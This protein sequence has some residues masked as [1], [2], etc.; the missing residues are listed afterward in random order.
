MPE[1]FRFRSDRSLVGNFGYKSFVFFFTRR[2][3]FVF[4]ARLSLPP[5]QRSIPWC[6]AKLCLEGVLTFELSPDEMDNATEVHNCQLLPRGAPSSTRRRMSNTIP[7]LEV[8]LEVLAPVSTQH[9]NLRRRVLLSR[10]G[11]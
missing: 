7:T 9:P 6:D 2:C 11:M 4:T 1:R 8:L 3:T 10:R 5:Q